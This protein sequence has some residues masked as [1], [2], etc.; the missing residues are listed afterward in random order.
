MAKQKLDNITAGKVD[1]LV[2][3]CPFCTVMYEDNQK[4]IEAKFNA[5]YNLPVLYYP[6]IL[7]LALGLD[8]KELGF[9][10]NKVKATELL[11]KME[12]V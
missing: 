2:T 7:G 8:P 6:Q 1:A 10:L 3:I 11:N 4:K 5:T 9:R 12:A